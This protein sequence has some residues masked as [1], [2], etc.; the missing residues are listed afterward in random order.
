MNRKLGQKQT[1]I[2]YAL[3]FDVRRS[4]K[5]KPL[6]Y[7]KKQKREKKIIEKKKLENTIREREK[8]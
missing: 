3:F 7:A 1:I 6:D 4:Y 5:I 2:V 8:K